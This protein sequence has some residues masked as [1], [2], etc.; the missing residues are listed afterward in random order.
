MISFLKTARSA[1]TIVSAAAVLGAGGA[2]A[3]PVHKA[4]VKASQLHAK[5]T[6][7]QA[8]ATVLKKF[9]GKIVAKTKLENEE[10][11]WQYGVM[12]QS[13]KTLREVMVGAKSGKIESVE[14][15]TA[16][17]EGVEAKQESAKAHAS[18]G[19]KPV[20]K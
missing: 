7:A 15:T 6:A 10:G 1:V 5:I 2:Y 19:A 4:P 12:V 16:G 9:P 13:G 18:T 17:K 3:A 14:V 20:K 8:E 11:K